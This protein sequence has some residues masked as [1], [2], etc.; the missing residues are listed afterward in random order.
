MSPAE[1]VTFATLYTR[2]RAKGEVCLGL[3]REG[4]GRPTLNPPKGLKVRPA[5]GDKLIVLGEAF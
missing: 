5:K 2:A 3:R 1:E 4:D